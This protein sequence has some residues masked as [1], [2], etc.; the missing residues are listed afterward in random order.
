[1]SAGSI[2]GTAGNHHNNPLRHE[3]VRVPEGS[4]IYVQMPGDHVFLGELRPNRLVVLP[5]WVR[6]PDTANSHENVAYV[7]MPSGRSLMT[8]LMHVHN[9]NNRNVQVF[10]CFIKTRNNTIFG[11][12]LKNNN[13]VLHDD[14]DTR[15]FVHILGHHSPVLS[16]FVHRADGHPPAWLLE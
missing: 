2:R 12:F 4:L 7:R 3:I 8:E 13:N 14:T 5:L 10:R 16:G 9:G 15:V 6:Q 1:M 11:A